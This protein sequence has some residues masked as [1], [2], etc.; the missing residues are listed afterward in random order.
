MLF[1]AGRRIDQFFIVMFF[2]VTNTNLLN[3]FSTTSKLLVACLTIIGTGVIL[4][5]MHWQLGLFILLLNPIVIF[6]TRSLGN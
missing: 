6:F 3:G 4:L 2:S 5:W 1:Y